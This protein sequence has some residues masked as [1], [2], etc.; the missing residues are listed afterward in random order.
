MAMQHD[1]ESMSEDMGEM[2]GCMGGQSMKDAHNEM[3]KQEVD[4]GGKE[5]TKLMRPQTGEDTE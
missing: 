4:I 2:E 1:K 5:N 3:R